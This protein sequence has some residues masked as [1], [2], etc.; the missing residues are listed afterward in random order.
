MTPRTSLA[1]GGINTKLVR[2][3]LIQILAISVA[4]VLG[5]FVAGLIAERVLVK[6][7]LSGEAEHFWDH[8]EKDA[9]FPLPNTNNLTGYLSVSGNE[10]TLPEWLRGHED[11]FYRV[12]HSPGFEPL[13]SVSSRG[14][15]RLFLVF[16]EVQVSQLAL[17]FGLAPLTA[18]LLLIYLLT[19]VGYVMSRRAVSTMVKL[20]DRVRNYDLKGGEFEPFQATE[21]GG[22]DDSEALTLVNAFNQFITRMESSMQRE[23][24]FTR[25]ASHEL[26][27][28]LAVVK[29]NL[30]LLERFDRPDKRQSVIDRMRRTV[31]GM[32][33]LVET[34][35]LLAREAESSLITSSVSLNELL[36]E[37]LEELGE[38]LSKPGV[39]YRLSAQGELKIEA[40]KRVL[41]IL[42]TNLVRNAMMYT[43]SGSVEVIIDRRGVVVKDTGCG[44]GEGDI[45]RMFEPFVRGHDRS[46]E[47]Y[48]LGLAIV[49]RLCDRFGWDLRATSE[50]GVG[51][52]IHIEF[53]RAQYQP[54]R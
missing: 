46:N 38:A 48:G 14:D 28:P 4:T 41:A 35:L 1:T 26:R 31:D 15:A 18:V 11:G 34:L 21:F 23:R 32:E 53:P 42:F 36:A 52:E 54:Q 6:E 10:Q 19:W 33:D 43:D 17:Y 47:G 27:T 5:V 9:A 20:A 13:V 39:V 8:Y 49:W 7:A 3:F 51:T 40:P 50:E 2:V 24:N 22:V 45:E 12:H 30:D 37:L 29:A 44:M 16:D 25:N